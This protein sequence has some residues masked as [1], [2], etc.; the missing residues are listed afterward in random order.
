MYSRKCEGCG[1]PFLSDTSNKALCP[2]CTR[3][4]KLESRRKAMCKIRGTHYVPIYRA[5]SAPEGRWV[6]EAKRWTQVR[7]VRPD[8]GPDRGVS[9]E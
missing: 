4:R 3:F 8:D 9:G 5:R 7:S 2:E 6:Y 1:I